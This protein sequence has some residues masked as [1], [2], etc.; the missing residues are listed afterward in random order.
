MILQV[1]VVYVRINL[2]STSLA[3][4]LQHV[5]LED[6][7]GGQISVDGSH[8]EQLRSVRLLRHGATDVLD[9]GDREQT[10]RDHDDLLLHEYARGSAGVVGCFRDFAQRHSNLVQD[11]NRSH[12]GTPR[13]VPN[14]RE[15][16]AVHRQPARKKPRLC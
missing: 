1:R 6:L 3:F 9:L 12:P 14:H 4:R 15:P 10:L 5:H 7:G 16:S 2:Q 13:V 8:R 11:G